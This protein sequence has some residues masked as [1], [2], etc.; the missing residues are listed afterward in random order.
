[1]HH[2]YHVNSLRPSDTYMHQLTYHH[3]QARQQT[4]FWTNAVILLIRPLGTNLCEILIEIYIFSFK[5]MH[6][7]MWSGNWQPFCRGLNVLSSHLL[8]LSA[9]FYPELLASHQMA[10]NT[11]MAIPLQKKF[12]KAFSWLKPLCIISNL[13]EFCCWGNSWWYWFW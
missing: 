6:L 11:K 12:S 8:S 1:M 9:S 3:W 5:K 13:I 10:I 7:K 4:I 2:L